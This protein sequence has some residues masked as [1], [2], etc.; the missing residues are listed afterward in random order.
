MYFAKCGASVAAGT[1]KTVLVRG[2]NALAATI[3]TPQAAPVIAATRLRGGIANTA[4][5]AASLIAQGI[6]TAREAGA[7]GPS[8]PGRNLSSQMRHKAA[9]VVCVGWSSWGWFAGGWLIHARAG[10]WRGRG[11]RW[12]RSGWAR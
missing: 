5:G 7:P 8:S 2:L 9:C 1:G 10:I 12:N 6:G 11:R 3:C 4:R